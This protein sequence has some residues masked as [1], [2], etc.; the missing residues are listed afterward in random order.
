MPLPVPKRSGRPGPPPPPPSSERFREQH[1]LGVVR[2]CAEMR[3]PL[4][5]DP[6]GK[7]VSVRALEQA[8]QYRIDH[9]IVFIRRLRAVGDTGQIPLHK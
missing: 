9:A 3:T 1:V 5:A 7:R 8:M 2:A 6:V 4:V